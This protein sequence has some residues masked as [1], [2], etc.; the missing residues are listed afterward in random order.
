MSM[1]QI[2]GAGRGKL[3]SIVEARTHK[4]I[5]FAAAKFYFFCAKSKVCAF[6]V[7]YGIINHVQTH[8]INFKTLTS[9]EYLF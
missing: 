6:T 4:T 3:I 5:A 2:W 8:F 1:W 7:L 9:S